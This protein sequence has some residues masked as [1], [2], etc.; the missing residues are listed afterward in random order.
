M[1]YRA[2]GDKILDSKS[3][4]L[5]AAAGVLTRY[6]ELRPN[7]PLGHIE[8]AEVYEAVEAEMRAMHLADLVASLPQAAVQALVPVDVFVLDSV[9]MQDGRGMISDVARERVGGMTGR[10]R[11][12]W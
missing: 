8:L 3:Q 9:R 6:T 1:I 10:A 11:W 5:V 7:N 4:G 12:S 2:Q